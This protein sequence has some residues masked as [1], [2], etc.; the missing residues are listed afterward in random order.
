MA[1][2]PTTLKASINTSML[3]EN[4][5]FSSIAGTYTRRIYHDHE[6]KNVTITLFIQEKEPGKLTRIF[7]LAP[8]VGRLASNGTDL[9]LLKIS[10][11]IFDPKVKISVKRHL[12]IRPRPILRW[13]RPVC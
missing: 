6:E 8:K 4:E 3:D 7:D 11:G 5:E 12:P 10:F 2:D 9:G 13:V 1:Y